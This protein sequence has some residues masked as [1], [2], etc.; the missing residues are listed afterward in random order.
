M[1][2]TLLA[3]LAGIATQEAAVAYGAIAGTI[4]A[5]ESGAPL[6]GA[7]ISVS[8]LAGAVLSAADGQYELHAIPAGFRQL[9]IR[10]LGYHSRSLRVLVPRDGT[11]QLNVALSPSPVHLRALVVQGRPVGSAGVE[12]PIRQQSPA[13]LRTRPL[14]AEPDAFAGLSSGE[15]IMAPESPSGIHIR[16]GA[17]DQTGFEIDGIPVFNPVHTAG[18]LSAL[19]PDALDLVTIATGTRAH[20]LSGVVSAATRAP[21]DRLTV[22]G[23]VSS[24]QA[25]ATISGPAG[26]PSSGMLLSIRA[27]FPGAVIPDREPSYL[28]G[29]SADWL[30]KFG[31]PVLG[32]RAQFIGYGNENTVS[33]ASHATGEDAAPSSSRNGFEWH[34]TSIGAEWARSTFD[35]AIRVMAWRATTS[36]AG[37]WTHAAAPM[38]LSGARRDAG[39]EALVEHAALGGRTEASVGVT[40]SRTSYRVEASEGRLADRTSTPLLTLRASHAIALGRLDLQAGAA[41]VAASGQLFMAPE[42]HVR[43]TITDQLRLTGSA[44]R[45]HQFAQS[46]RNS[47]SLVSGI[48]P[49]DLYLGSAHPSVPV[50]RSDQAVIGM[51]YQPIRSV[52]FITNAWSRQFYGLLLVAPR[53]GAP[54]AIDGVAVGEG[55]AHGFALEGTVSRASAH[56]SAS[57]GMQWIGIREGA[58]AYV[59]G[60]GARQTLQSGVT[61]TPTG[62]ISLTLGAM[63][64]WGRRT[65]MATGALE[66]ESCS[67]LDE[68]CEFAGSPDHSGYDLGATSLPA[69]FRVD[70][71]IRKEWS[72]RIAGRGGKVALFGTMTNLLARRNLLSFVRDPGSEVLTAIEMRS[73]VPLVAGIDW[74]F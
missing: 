22:Q 42:V 66:W 10:R 9:T 52:R 15:V 47:E 26:P 74:R 53:S 34:S 31:I 58:S 36:A 65:T 64:I 3:V 44:T 48:F 13:A 21:G 67:L 20:R 56:Y 68:G 61:L 5:E 39:I 4:R 29:E 72:A 6:G 33:T 43:W 73:R 32:G 17:S 14:L 54:F 60:Y 49:V 38:R 23:G 41:T 28:R 69:Y 55:S 16:G 19:N 37:R 70:L 51:D 24:T 45:A 50:A 59:P 7:S 71:G 1:V 25:R 57:Y 2:V 35:G 11:V 63:G 12:A 46:L 62:S 27:G 30:A 40:T 8:G 18:I